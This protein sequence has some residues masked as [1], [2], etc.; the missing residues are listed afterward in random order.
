MSGIG[1]LG[2]PVSGLGSS[3]GLKGKRL[4]S[5]PVD[6]RKAFLRVHVPKHG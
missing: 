6:N 5:C 2:F 4:L 1:V 3:L